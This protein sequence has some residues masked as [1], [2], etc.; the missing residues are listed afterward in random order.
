MAKGDRGGV[1]RAGGGGGVNPANIKNLDSL[2]SAREG[3]PKE[4]DQVLTVARS[5]Y[6][7]YGTELGDFM[8]ADITGKDSNT[9]AYSD[10]TN[11]GFNRSY[12]DDKSMNGAY[13]DCI[14]SGFHPSRGNKSAIEAVAAHEFG[15]VLSEAVARKMGITGTDSM[16]QA[17]TAIVKEAVK[18]TKH[19]GVVQM[20]SKI[21]TYATA[22]NAEAIAE[23][24]S[25]VFCNGKKA[26]QE[27][28]AIVDVINKYLK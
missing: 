6:D 10:G 28:R 26:K 23:A 24:V 16:Q 4:V 18:N 20:A 13:D 2:V 9:L 21:S 15:H 27:S 12:F 3:N 22:T 11:I 14:K 25:D 1:R 5:M 17:S 19:R 7:N 8:L